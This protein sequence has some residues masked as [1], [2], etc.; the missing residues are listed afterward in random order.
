MVKPFASYTT[1]TFFVVCTKIVRRN[2]SPVAFPVDD[3]RN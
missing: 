3:V 2:Q 1:L